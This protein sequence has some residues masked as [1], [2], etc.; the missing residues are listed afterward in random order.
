MLRHYTLIYST[1]LF[2]N[3]LGRYYYMKMSFHFTN[4]MGQIDKITYAV[5]N[6]FGLILAIYREKPM[7]LF[8]VE[9]QSKTHASLHS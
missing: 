8:D 2:K 6:K 7:R 1:I 5:Y 4:C 3:T 9:I